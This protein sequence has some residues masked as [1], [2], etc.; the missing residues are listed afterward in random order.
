MNR[1]PQP[2][3]LF[4][5]SQAAE[6]LGRS[7]RLM[8]TILEREN[9]IR[10]WK[11]VCDNKGAP[12][13][14]G[15]KI[16]QLWDYLKDH[17]PSIKQDLLNTTY[18]PRPVKRV[19]IPKPD[20]GIRLLGIPTVLD[21]VIQQAI[22]QVLSRIWEPFFS[23]Y[24]YGFRPGRAAHQA[25]MQGK[26]YMASGYTYVVDMDLSKF[27]DRVNHDRLMSRLAGRI[28]DKRV[29]KL[30][31]GYLRCG[32]MVAGVSIRS[33]EGT[34]QGGPLSPLLSNIVLDE[35]DKELE[36]R[37]HRFV[38]YADDFMIYCRSKKAAERVKQNITRYLHAKLKLKVNQDKS[39]V[40][41]PWLCK[42][43]GFTYFQMCGQSKVRIHA[44]SLKRFK[45]KVRGLTGRSRGKSLKQVIEELNQFFI[46]WWGYFRLTEAKSF[47]KGL[48]TWIMRRL[49]SLVWKQWKN[50]K[51]RVANLKKLGITHEDAMLCGNA[52]KKY[53]H[54]SKIKWVAVAMP[55]RFFTDRRLCFPG[56]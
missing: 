56:Y 4:A 18:K 43:L 47:L 32:V 21:R 22:S 13:V 12:G 41:R 6:R 45:D 36:K 14:D 29:L 9:L 46:G 5:A 31:R 35:L 30:I 37:G 19:E 3:E 49:R 25:V 54:M 26:R 7:D 55:E 40:S 33:E 20:G 8:D 39:A 17:W 52:R 42:F 38:R 11:R 16:E 48:K 34:P 27:F 44:K 51:T 2:M 53:W 24:S 15:M 1:M 23:E 50:P 28:E 10:A